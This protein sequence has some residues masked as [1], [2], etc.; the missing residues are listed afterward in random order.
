MNESRWHEVEEEINDLINYI[1]KIYLRIIFIQHN[2]G[3]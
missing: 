2:D 3:K 1:Y